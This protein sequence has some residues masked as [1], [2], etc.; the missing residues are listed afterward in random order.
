MIPPPTEVQPYTY[1]QAKHAISTS[2]H[3]TAQ[4]WK[5]LHFAAGVF[6]TI[7]RI[8]W[9]PIIPLVAISVPVTK[10]EKNTSHIVRSRISLFPRFLRGCCGLV[11]EGTACP[12]PCRQRRCEADSS[13]ET[14]LLP[15]RVGRNRPAEKAGRFVFGGELSFHIQAARSCYRVATDIDS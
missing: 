4:G 14:N 10:K 8:F 5:G 11:H 13:S 3:A 12:P 9:R 6:Y 15:R 7:K 2:T 1:R